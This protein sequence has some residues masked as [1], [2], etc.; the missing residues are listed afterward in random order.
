MWDTELEP[1][2][3]RR[4]RPWWRALLFVGLTWPTA[5]L[6]GPTEPSEPVAVQ[7]P[8][9]AETPAEDEPKASSKRRSSKAR[10][11][12]KSNGNKKSAKKNKRVEEPAHDEDHEHHAHA[13]DPTLVIAGDRPTRAPAHADCA[14]RMPLFEHEV[15]RGEHLGLIAGRYGVHHTEL[16]ALNPQ[17][18]DPNLIRPGDKVRV[19]PE[20]FPRLTKTIEH[21]VQ[22]GES[23][24][25]IATTLGVTK[26]VLLDE[27]PDI[28]D[29]NL[30]QVGQRLV[31]HVDG[32]LVPDFLPPEP[33]RTGGKTAKRRKH[34]RVTVAL[35]KTDDVYIKRPTLAFGTDK[36]IRLMQRAIGQYKKQYRRSPKVL[37]GDLSRKGGGALKPHLSHRTGRDIDLGYVLKAEKSQRVRFGGVTPETLDVP[38]TWALL[39]AFIDTREVVYI[40]VDYNIQKQLYEYAKGRGV[41]QRELDALFQY[42]HGR[43]RAHGI[44]RHWRSHRHHFHV[45]FRS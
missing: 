9:D 40:F 42:P 39:K 4:R 1:R 3:I 28:T 27:N 17:I 10:G 29:P 32:G 2:R 8:A 45:R 12:T 37:V 6:A 31:L 18:E 19:C 35:P 21:E 20:I 25:A 16:V 15:E 30:I 14:Y 22:P 11:K 44:I 24:G 38:R 23:L 26:Q 5:A 43:R 41:P 34:A 33:K 13:E 36:T 7:G